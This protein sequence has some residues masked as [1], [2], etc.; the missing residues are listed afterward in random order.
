MPDGIRNPLVILMPTTAGYGVARMYQIVGDRG[1]PLVQVVRTMHETLAAL[2]V[3]SS[4]F[5]SL[6]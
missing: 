6:A 1:Q 5:E 3:E 2:A 4:H